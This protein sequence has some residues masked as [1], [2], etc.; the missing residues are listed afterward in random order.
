[1]DLVGCARAATAK[2]DLHFWRRVSDHRRLAGKSPGDQG[3]IV[4]GGFGGSRS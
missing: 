4:R 3:S 2:V 1:M